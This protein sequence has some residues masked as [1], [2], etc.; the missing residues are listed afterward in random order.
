MNDWNGQNFSWKN[1]DNKNHLIIKYEDLIKD[2]NELI[3]IIKFINK[4]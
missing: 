2:R 4:F 1:F 3:K